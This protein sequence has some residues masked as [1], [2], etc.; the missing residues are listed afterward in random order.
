MATR[1]RVQREMREGMPG[2]CNR[3]TVWDG[4]DVTHEG[5]IQVY[6]YPSITK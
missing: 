6:K 5:N 3:G 2:F 1:D 4:E